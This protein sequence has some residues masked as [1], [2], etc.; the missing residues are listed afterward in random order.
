MLGKQDN[1][2]PGG[3]P[4][5]GANNAPSWVKSHRLRA[6]AAC[7]TREFAIGTD[8]SVAGQ[9]DRDRIQAIGHAYRPHGFGAAE[10]LGQ[11]TVGGDVTGWNRP[12]SLPD[13]LLKFRAARLD[14]QGVQAMQIPREVSP[15]AIAHVP[16]ARD[17]LQLHLTV[18]FVQQRHHAVFAVCKVNG[19]SKGDN[20]LLIYTHQ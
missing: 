16:W 18:A 12:Q 4:G 10:L 15:E 13:L 20:P 6:Q 7:V 11:V 19:T 5:R 2:F 17:R 9:D 14:G 3:S 8:D 1:C